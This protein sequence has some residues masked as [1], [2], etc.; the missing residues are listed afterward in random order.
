MRMIPMFG[1]QVG[2]TSNMGDR[3]PFQPL[4]TTQ[5]R[6]ASVNTCMIINST[7]IVQL[8][9]KLAA[10]SS[11]QANLTSADFLNFANLVTMVLMS[12]LLGAR[13]EYCTY[14]DT[15]PVTAGNASYR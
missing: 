5:Q 13:E 2:L 15:L 10:L 6:A 8:C 7:S 12:E 4:F 1:F 9:S 3:S 11:N 14:S